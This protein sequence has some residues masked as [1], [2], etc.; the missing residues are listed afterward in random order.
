MDCARLVLDRS[1][2]LLLTST[3]CFLCHPGLLAARE[4]RD[5]VFCQMRR[6]LDLVHFI[7]K[8]SVVDCAAKYGVEDIASSPSAAM[9]SGALSAATGGVDGADSEAA[10]AKAEDTTVLKAIKYF[11]DSV[12][13]MH[14]SPVSDR[15][16]EQLTSCLD[17]IVESTQDFTD[18]AYTGNERRQNILLLCERTKADLSHLL[19]CLD[20]GEA[21]AGNA[22]VAAGLLEM[23]PP[24]SPHLLPTHD[25]MRCLLKTTADLRMELEQ[26]A[27][28]HS[29]SVIRNCRVGIDVLNGLRE[30]AL[31]GVGVGVVD[32]DGRCDFQSKRF[33]EHVE[34]I[35]DA[36]KLVRHVTASEAAQIRA[37]HAQINLGIYGPQVCVAARTVCQA[38]SLS[39]VARANLDAF[40]G[41]WHAL[42]DDIVMIAKRVQQQQQ[43]MRLP[44]PPPPHHPSSNLNP[45]LIMKQPPTPSQQQGPPPPHLQDCYLGMM[46]PHSAGPP[47]HR[48]PA[49]ATVPG[50]FNTSVP[51]LSS[52]GGPSVPSSAEHFFPT[53]RSSNFLDPS[54]IPNGGIAEPPR[55]HSTSSV[56]GQY[57]QHQHQQRHHHSPDYA[58]AMQEHHHQR[59]RPW[60]AYSGPLPPPPYYPQQQQQQQQQ[61]LHPS[62]RGGSIV[63]YYNSSH[64]SPE[65]M[66]NSYQVNFH[67]D[68]CCQLYFLVLAL[69]SYSFV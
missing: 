67:T 39:K 61:Q 53:H 69:S 30:A 65:E 36:S 5:T 24:S 9:D 68:R 42:V 31:G 34:Y 21:A 29:F 25:A 10:A 49:S 12:E 2:T 13:I 50:K 19:H 3:K 23:P 58:W 14:M 33:L 52:S 1:S 55:R 26:T 59:G 11:S 43:A 7:V 22:A 46:P 60:D 35:E 66:L 37:K 40:C 41:M 44:P 51:N 18:S 62:Y 8:E 54:M 32:V 56:P 27:L 38:G 45:P 16:K 20:L 4:N 6:A 17:S 47:P 28:E 15:Y 57:H 64:C 48:H 63:P